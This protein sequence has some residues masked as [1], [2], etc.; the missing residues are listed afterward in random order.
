MDSSSTVLSA[1]LMLLTS[2]LED[3]VTPLVVS[4]DPLQIEKLD[5]TYE[6]FLTGLWAI[7]PSIAEDKPI[8]RES[9]YFTEG[10]G[11]IALIHECA[12]AWVR[13]N[14]GQGA[15]KRFVFPDSIQGKDKVNKLMKIICDKITSVYA[16]EGHGHVGNTLAKLVHLFAEKYCDFGRKYYT[17]QKISYSHVER[18]VF[19]YE[20]ITIKEKGKVYNKVQRKSFYRYNRSPFLRGGERALLE[21]LFSEI[22]FEEDKDLRTPWN[23]LGASEQHTQFVD[24][25]A[26]GR[27]KL[28]EY[29]NASDKVSQALNKRRIAILSA[30]EKTISKKDKKSLGKFYSNLMTEFNTVPHASLKKDVAETLN[31][32]WLVRTVPELTTRVEKYLFDDPPGGDETWAKAKAAWI[33]NQRVYGGQFKVDFPPKEVASYVSSWGMQNRFAILTEEADD[34]GD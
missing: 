10:N 34:E 20:T 4:A 14:P 17:Q 1:V 12:E 26:K 18:H 31:T 23:A 33:Q 21:P 32:L 28:T 30:M 3:K 22:M 6:K 8:G 16:G 13:K 27:E 15:T 5:P 7:I 25:C 2:H 11:M 29:R 9:D 24:F 19:K